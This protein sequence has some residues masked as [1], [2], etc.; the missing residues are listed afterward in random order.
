MTAR[1]TA[2]AWTLV[3]LAL[4]AG[5]EGSKKPATAKA[6]VQPRETLNKTTQVVL[7]LS[8]ALAQGGVLAATTIEVADPLTQS[9]SAYRT[10]VAKLAAMKVKQAIDIRNASN[11]QDPKPVSH[12]ELMTEFIKPAQGEG[13]ALPMLPYYQEYAWDEANQQLVP[14]DFPKRKADVEKQEKDRRDNL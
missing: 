2:M 7:K 3:P 9:A 14:V 10:Q 12:E 6:K 5:C 13:I 4:L 11:I 8:D 1:L